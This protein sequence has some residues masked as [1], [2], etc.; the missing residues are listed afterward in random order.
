MRQTGSIVKKRNLYYIAYRK[1]DKKQEWEGGFETKAKARA[2]LTEVL[3]QMDTGTYV[4]TTEE[5]FSEFADKWLKSRVGIKGSTWQNYESYLNVHVKPVLG[6]AKLKNIRPSTVQDLVAELCQKKAAGTER[7]LSANTIGKVVTMLKTLFKAAVKDRIIHVNPVLDVELPKVIKP[8]VQP[9]DKKDVI[10]ILQ[11]ATPEM[12]TL[13]LLDSMTGLRR[14][15]LLALQWRD[16]DWLNAEVLVERAISKAKA[17]DGVHK[18]QWVLST[19][20]GG[21]SR[22]VGLAPVVLEWLRNLRSGLAAPPADS[23]FIFTRDGSFIDP[24]YFT[25]WMAIPLIKQATKGRMNRFHNLR[26]FF[27][28]VLIDNGESPKYIQDQ[29]G[30]A[31]ITTTFDMYGHLMPQAKRT[32]TKKL[33][34]SIFGKTNVEHL[35]NISDAKESIN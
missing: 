17:T 8:K 34:R 9:P 7:L 1:A 15:E 19:T 16:I 33:E 4:E 18:Y 31:S 3:R 14:G 29:V 26:H 13:F 24:E 27:T 2:R 25:K 6:T 11:Q 12:K 10:A 5:I 28:S 20:K 23:D 32:A 30:H 35:L 21:R 22:R